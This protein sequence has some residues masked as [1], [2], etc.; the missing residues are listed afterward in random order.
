[1]AF[2][3]A[4]LV[5]SAVAGA[6]AHG[7]GG[8]RGAH[9]NYGPVNPALGAHGYPD[10][11]QPGP[12][13]IN[14]VEAN[15]FSMVCEQRGKG[16]AALKIA[17]VGD[18]IT[19][20]AH[21]S[22]PAMAYPQQLQS[23]LDPS[24]YAVT[25]LGACGSTMQKAGDSPYWQRPQYQTLI[26]NTWDIV[27]IMLGTNDAKDPGDGGPNNWKPSGACGTPDAIRLD[28]CPFANDS[29][30]LI[31]VIR[32]LGTTPGVPPTIYLAAP[33]PLMQHGS[34]GANQTV[35]NSIY[36]VLSP[37]IAQAANLST[38][39]ISIY[40]AMGGTPGW[41]VAFPPSCT[42]NSPWPACGYYCDAQSCDQCHPNDVGYTHLAKSMKAGLNL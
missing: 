10:C 37:L 5:A 40:A 16:T 13:D 36:P 31:N 28:N 18:S 19:A 23:M 41:E 7:S 42:L 14:D 25:N 27:V 12:F 3:R 15:Q 29:L 4:L 6:S 8:H 22:G 26:S 2:A 24:A 38:V 33:P 21:A 11:H 35:I 34:I 17:C 39:D 9:D 30:A 1:M 32:G 20:G